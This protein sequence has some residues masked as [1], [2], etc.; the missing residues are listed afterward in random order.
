MQPVIIENDAMRIGAIYKLARVVY[1]ETL[2]RSLVAAEALCSMIANLHYKTGRALSDIAQDENLFESLHE[3]SARHPAIDI[4]AN[5]RDFQMCLRT[6]RRMAN[7]LLPDSVMGATRFH[8]TENLPEWAV[9]AGYI[10]EID[11]MLFYL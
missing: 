6:V 10:M 5:R 2:G 3:N 7:G 4:D 8:R 1:A 9:N 11:G